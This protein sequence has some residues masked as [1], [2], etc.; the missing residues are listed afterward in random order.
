VKHCVHTHNER[1]TMQL[2]RRR[3]VLRVFSSDLLV[4]SIAGAITS[5]WELITT[6]L[7]SAALITI[8]R[9]KLD[10]EGAN[11]SR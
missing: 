9:V 2:V 1:L 4:L 11:G 5:S 10:I 6:P 3:N 7:I 8:K